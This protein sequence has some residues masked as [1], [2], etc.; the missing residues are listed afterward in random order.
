[1]F[2]SGIPITM[3][4]LDVCEQTHLHEHTV[5]SLA[6]G[7]T[8]LARFVASAVQPWIDLRRSIYGTNDLHLY[9]SL[10]VAVAFD[11]ALVRTQPAFVVVETEGTH[12]AGETVAHL[13]P[14]LRAAFARREPNA[15][16][17]LQLDADR[18]AALFAERVVDPLSRG[19]LS[20][21]SR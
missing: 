7:T 10:A 5:K 8:D 6:A 9:D 12:T 17:A 11:P 3:V 14:I 16:V 2:E 15:D 4:G 20:A 21:S 18:F 19:T 1:V 13:N